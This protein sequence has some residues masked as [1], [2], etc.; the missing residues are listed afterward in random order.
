MS[1]VKVFA[2]CNGGHHLVRLDRL[3]IRHCPGTAGTASTGKPCRP[4]ALPRRIASPI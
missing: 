2:R 3:E 4:T 1:V